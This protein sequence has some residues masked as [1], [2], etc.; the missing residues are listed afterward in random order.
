MFSEFPSTSDFQVRVT[1][2]A[3]LWEIWKTE[4][5]IVM[6]LLHSEFWSRA[7]GVVLSHIY[8]C[9]F[10]WFTWSGWGAGSSWALVAGPAPAVSSCRSLA[11]GSAH[12]KHHDKQKYH[13]RWPITASKLEPRGGKR[14]IA[15]VPIHPHRSH[16]GS[17]LSFFPIFLF[18]R[19][20]KG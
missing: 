8:G 1:L 4:N 18:Q 6:F 20:P 2:R 11:P 17:N 14:P 13:L 9:L 19:L 15:Q 10:C 3:V 12:L 5:E 16:S 7:K